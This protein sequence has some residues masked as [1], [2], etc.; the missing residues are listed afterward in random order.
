[1]G[2]TAQIMPKNAISL[3]SPTK[4]VVASGNQGQIDDEW[5]RVPT[6][7]NHSVTHTLSAPYVQFMNG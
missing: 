6:T 7:A 4:S 2:I 5:L 3:L 1:M